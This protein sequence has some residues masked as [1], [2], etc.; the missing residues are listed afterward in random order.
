M[1]ECLM[2]TRGFQIIVLDDMMKDFQLGQ[3]Q[4]VLYRVCFMFTSLT[5]CVFAWS[6]SSKGI[7]SCFPGSV[8][9]LLVHLLFLTLAALTVIPNNITPSPKQTRLHTQAY[10]HHGR[11]FTLAL[12]T[13]R[14]QNKKQDIKKNKTPHLL[15]QHSHTPSWKLL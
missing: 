10:T 11:S 13:K 15:R 6:A 1:K 14:K 5:G 3:I 12:G 7:P 2:E 8:L 4:C 9:T